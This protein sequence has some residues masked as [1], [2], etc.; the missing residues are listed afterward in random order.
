MMHGQKNIK[1]RHVCLSLFLVSKRPDF[2]EIWLVYC[3]FLPT[4]DYQFNFE[5]KNEKNNILRKDMLKGCNIS[6][7]SGKS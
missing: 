5:W 7:S 4:Y 2:R 1:L 3:E 6:L